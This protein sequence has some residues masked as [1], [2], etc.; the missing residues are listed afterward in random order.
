M[1]N[2]TEFDPKKDGWQF[3]NW[4]EHPPYCLESSCDLSWD[5]YK[6]T[7]LGISSDSPLDN[8]FYDIV[9]NCIH[10]GH[11]FGMSLLAL[12]IF[13]YGGYMGFCS[14]ASFYSGIP[15]PDPNDGGK[16][17]APARVDLHKI[18]SIMH[19]RQYSA[20]GIQYYIDLSDAGNYNNAVAAFEK[21]KECLGKGDYPLLTIATGT[22]GD[23]NNHT[24]IPYAIE[25]NNGT[26]IMYIWDSNFPSDPDRY[27]SSKCQ[28]IINSAQDWTYGIGD[29][30]T[31]YIG[32][33]GGRCFAIPMSVV[34]E[35]ARQPMSLDLAINA[36]QNL[37]TLYAG[38]TNATVS[39][40]S[41]DEGHRFYKNEADMHESRNDLE[42]DQSKKLMGVVRFEG[43]SDIA[44][45]N[46][47]GELYFMK[48]PYGSGPA[49]N[50]KICSIESKLI[51]SAAGN[52]I[53]INSRSDTSSRDIIRIS[54]ST[55][56]SPCIRIETLADSRSF[57]IKLFRAAI[58]GTDWKRFDLS[59]INL[60]HGVPLSINT[61][62]NL[63]A[64]HISS[65]DK[66]VG[67]D[68]D[69]IQSLSG[70]LTIR[71][72]GRRSTVLGK[73][74]RVIPHNWNELDKTSI[75]MGT[76]YPRP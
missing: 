58:G 74:L 46:L 43:S 1:T 40:I 61:A 69:I 49:L 57:Q 71:N 3:R 34:L 59:N 55:S 2:W 5:L 26:K 35:E 72:V 50:I 70:K 67:F 32:K 65:N 36:L 31:P 54:R 75:K 28:L 16:I 20:P 56:I 38:G 18:L 27:S 76:F 51:A 47:P 52:L 11:C 29:Y 24:V 23:G 60:T 44:G 48:Q 6:E 10:G 39:Q 37:M 25:E 63:E 7:Y 14:P 19:A 4:G 41:D 13:K 17:K 64:V 33:D 62:G 22:L 30:S 12:A 42:T 73:V 66:E 53:E 21:V 68:L 15:D 45:G 9:K 8:A